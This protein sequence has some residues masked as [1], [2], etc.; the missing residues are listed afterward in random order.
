MIHDA[1]L[2]SNSQILRCGPF[3]TG[4]PAALGNTAADYDSSLQQVALGEIRLDIE[5][6]PLAAPFLRTGHSRSPF[7][8]GR[9]VERDAGD[10]DAREVPQ[11]AAKPGG[12]VAVQQ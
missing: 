7:L 2:H 12:D 1:V 9:Q 4:G 11:G 5:P 10:D 6:V 3:A 8:L